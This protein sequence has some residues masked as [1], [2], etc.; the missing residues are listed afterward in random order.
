MALI[1]H[2]VCGREPLPPRVTAEWPG[3]A[4]ACNQFCLCLCLGL[5][6]TPVSVTCAVAGKRLEKYRTTWPYRALPVCAIWEHRADWSA[7]VSPCWELSYLG[8]LT[9][10][11]PLRGSGEVPRRLLP[12]PG[13]GC[14]A[15]TA[16]ECVGKFPGSSR[17]QGILMVCQVR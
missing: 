7:F 8:Q 14:D 1:T 10:G 11:N 15:I 16:L 2:C 3:L 13:S 12:G 4:I 5:A 6:I 17:V 9:P